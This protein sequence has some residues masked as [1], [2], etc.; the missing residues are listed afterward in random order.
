MIH[1]L[2][3]WQ[4]LQ[5]FWSINWQLIEVRWT[6]PFVVSVCLWR[7][8]FQPV[9]Q[10]LALARFG[11]ASLVSADGGWQPQEEL[12]QPGVL[13]CFAPLSRYPDLC[14]RKTNTLCFPWP[15]CT[16]QKI[17]QLSEAPKS[18]SIK[19]SNRISVLSSF[20]SCNMCSIKTCRVSAWNEALAL[21]TER[22]S[23]SS[24]A[25]SLPVND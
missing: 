21:H 20:S 7:A 11:G 13:Q 18:K 10:Q 2:E 14:S 23:Q 6:D 17:K 8:C 5:H 25:E 9:T 12:P 22:C 19:D 3:Y 15:L 1:W 16:K 24:N 4:E